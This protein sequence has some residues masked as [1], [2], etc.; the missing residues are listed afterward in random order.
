MG[1]ERSTLSYVYAASYDNS[2]HRYAEV[3]PGYFSSWY[4]APREGV[5][6]LVPHS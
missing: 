4:R 3:L 5:Q 6:E 2:R 1:F